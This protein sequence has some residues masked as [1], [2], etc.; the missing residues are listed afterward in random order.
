MAIIARQLPHL[1]DVGARAAGGNVTVRASL[2]ERAWFPTKAYADFSLP[3]GYYPALKITLGEGAGHNWWCVVYPP[4]C[5]GSVSESVAE[6]AETFSSDQVALITGESEGYVVK[7][8]AM[9]LLGRLTHALSG[10]P[11]PAA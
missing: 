4:L 11:A 5:L 1:A 8:K 6:R 10:D 2:E 7:F 9:E 3:A